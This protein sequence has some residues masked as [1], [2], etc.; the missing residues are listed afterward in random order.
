VKSGVNI[1][2]QN[3]L[4]ESASHATGSLL[5]WDTGEYSILPS[6]QPHSRRRTKDSDSDSD[7]GPNPNPTNQPI[8]ENEKLQQAFR[9][10]RSPPPYSLT[11]NQ[12][13][14]SP[15][16][17]TPQGKFHIRLHG[18]RLPHNYTLV[19]RL[20]DLHAANPA[21][22]RKR[23]RRTNPRSTSKQ[24]TPPPSSPDQNSDSPPFAATS[25]PSPAVLDANASAREKEL[26]EEEDAQMRRTNA[27][28]GATNTIG[29]VHQRSWHLS[30]D[31]ASSGFVRGGEEGGGTGKRWVRKVEGG[32]MGRERGFEAFYVRGREVE[33]SVV[34]GRGA[35][36]V[37]ADEGVVGFVWRRG[38]RAVLE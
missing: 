25:T 31:K 16:L 32:G 5:I 17:T 37:C 8:S 28:P 13:K 36:E 27:Y 20:T 19:L 18:T 12:Q 14:G 9:T 7:S 15:T 33:R 23:R 38:W 30:L 34:T 24:E 6:S 4:I 29:S 3:H 26:A 10:V 35:G 11:P 21:P 22:K 1:E 2:V